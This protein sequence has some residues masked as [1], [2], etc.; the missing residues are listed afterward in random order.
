MARA[1]PPSAGRATTDRAGRAPGRPPRRP[2]DV[3]QVFRRLRRVVAPF[4]KAA[5]F[6]LADE[7]FASPFEQLLAC[8][9][10][11]RTTDEV[12]LVT[13][14]RLFAEARTPRALARMPHARLDG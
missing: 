12:M 6:E 2:F 5:M 13:A 14:R 1:T 9:L 8:I 10:S 7:G 3:A 4:P 11:I